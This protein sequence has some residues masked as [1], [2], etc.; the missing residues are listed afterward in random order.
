M[1]LQWLIQSK[2]VVDK[3]LANIHGFAWVLTRL[4]A[5]FLKSVGSLGDIAE[6]IDYL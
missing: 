3:W 2:P 6:Y 4:M 1:L 5:A